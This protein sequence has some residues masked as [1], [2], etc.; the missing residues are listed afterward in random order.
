MVRVNS[1]PEKFSDVP[2]LS[3]CYRLVRQ[4]AKSSLSAKGLILLSAVAKLFLL[5]GE[6]SS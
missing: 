1:C 5:I 3:A 4:Q 6:Q 2:P